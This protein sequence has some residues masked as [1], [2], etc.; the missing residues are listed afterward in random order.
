MDDIL[1]MTKLDFVVRDSKGDV[2][3]STVGAFYLAQTSKVAAVIGDT[4]SGPTISSQNVLK[5]NLFGIPQISYSATS[6]LLTV[7]EYNRFARTVPSDTYQTEVMV[8]LL[9]YYGFKYINTLGAGY[10]FFYEKI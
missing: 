2:G 8:A 9:K 5:L 3:W 4:A 10:I 7:L 6:A 1:P